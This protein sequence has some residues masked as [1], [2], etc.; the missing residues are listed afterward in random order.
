MKQANSLHI[1]RL[2]AAKSKILAKMC[3]TFA[4]NAMS[5]KSNLKPMAMLIS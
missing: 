4:D 2:P 3:G 5:D 1:F